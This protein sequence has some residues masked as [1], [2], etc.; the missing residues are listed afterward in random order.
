MGA[1]LPIAPRAPEKR[2]VR[3]D[4]F[5]FMLARISGI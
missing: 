5:L 1:S 3:A 4:L 2:F